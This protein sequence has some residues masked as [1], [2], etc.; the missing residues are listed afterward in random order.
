MLC[1]LLTDG[2]SPESATHFT[3]L[4][5]VWL[6]LTSRHLLCS[7]LDAVQGA[8]ATENEKGISNELD[9]QAGTS[10]DQ[11]RSIDFAASG[12]LTVSKWLVRRAQ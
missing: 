10:R 8:L 11:S 9:E 3:Q 1:P 6:E 2:A 5:V 7:L 4:L 12:L